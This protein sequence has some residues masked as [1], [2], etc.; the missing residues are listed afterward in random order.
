ALN[1]VADAVGHKSK[2]ST[3]S[4]NTSGNAI[5]LDEGDLSLS[6]A[7]VTA[8]RKMKENGGPTIRIDSSSSAAPVEGWMNYQQYLHQQSAVIQD[9]DK[10]NSNKEIEIEFF[11]DAHGKPTNVKVLTKM[12]KRRA[13]KITSIIENGPI[14]ETG[15]NDK[16]VKVIIQLH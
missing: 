9:S 1:V 15:Q 2:K 10:N 6:E 16:K 14:W 4:S 3:I 5:T 8:K 11:V 13:E 12:D 7:V